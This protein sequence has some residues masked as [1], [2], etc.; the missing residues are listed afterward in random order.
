MNRCLIFLAVAT[1]MLFTACSDDTTPE[2]GTGTTDAGADR[3]STNRDTGGTPQTDRGTNDPGITVPDQGLP[4]I[5]QRDEGTPDLGTPD[6]GVEDT[7]GL[8]SPDGGGS[9]LPDVG[10]TPPDLGVEDDA[11][12]TDGTDDVTT[13]LG[14]DLSGD[15]GDPLGTCANPINLNDFELDS[16]TWGDAFVLYDTAAAAFAPSCATAAS[17]GDTAEDVFSFTPPTAGRYYVIA[18][19][20]PDV[21]PDVDV[22]LSVWSDCGATEVACND[23]V[24]PTV[25]MD[26]LLYVDLGTDQVFIEVEP[27]S[28]E[29]NGEVYFVIVGKAEAGAAGATCDVLRDDGTDDSPITH[30]FDVASGCDWDAD[31]ACEDGEGADETDTDTCVLAPAPT[32]AQVTSSVVRGHTVVE[33]DELCDITWSAGETTD[34]VQFVIS[35][36]A[37]SELYGWSFVNADLPTRNYLY[38]IPEG[39]GIPDGDGNYEITVTLCL[40]PATEIGTALASTSTV[41]VI[42]TLA[43]TAYHPDTVY[44][45]YYSLDDEFLG[46]L[47]S[48]LES[49]EVPHDISE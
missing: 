29:Q 22:V 2:G 39:D 11:P 45:F 23:D 3:G 1:L 36:T 18:G 4:D 24:I 7:G 13:D 42:D 9:L 14:I 6:T 19:P 46:L 30:P 16:E 5:V 33:E 25:R 47:A 8:I 32:I 31:F 20:H 21:N 35:G 41:S 28:D 15:A 26:S 48:G 27:Y 40:D 17:R 44:V 38:G 49:N 43:A 12:V 34:Y 10:I 37:S